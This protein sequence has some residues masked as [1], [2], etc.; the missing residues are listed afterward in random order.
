MM[1]L[2]RSFWICGV[3][4]AVRKKAFKAKPLSLLNEWWSHLSS[5]QISQL[6][7]WPRRIRNDFRDL[8][9]CECKLRLKDRCDYFS[10]VRCNGQ[11]SAFVKVATG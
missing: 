3:A 1:E 11:V 6:P 7:S 10:E 9:G 2:H 8:R 5:D 4:E